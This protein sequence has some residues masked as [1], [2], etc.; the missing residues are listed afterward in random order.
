MISSEKRPFFYVLIA[1]L[2]FGM[3]ALFTREA[4]A[5][6]I[7][8][9]TWRAI[10]VA[11]LFGI[12][13]VWKKD[14]NNI[15]APESLKISVPYGLFLGLAS[16]TFVG[17]YAFTTVANTIFLHNL[18]PLFAIPLALWKFDEKAHP[19]IIAGALLCL[20]GVGLI[21]GVSLFHASHF[22][23]SRFLLGDF[24]A[25]VSAFGYAGVLVWTKLTRKADLPVLGTLFVAW[26]VAAVVLVVLSLFLGSLAISW[27]SFLWILGLAFF[28]TNLPFYFLNL[29]MKHVSA[30]MASLLSMSEILFAT[31]LGVLIYSETLA[32]IGWVGGILVVAGV[33]YPFLPEAEK[34]EEEYEQRPESWYKQRQNRTLFWLLS[35][36]TAVFLGEYEGNYILAMLCFLQ[37]IQIGAPTLQR[38]LDYRYQNAQRFGTGLLALGLLYVLI[39]T[40]FSLPSPIILLE[41]AFLYLGDTYFR[42]QEEALNAQENALRLPEGDIRFILAIL[43]FA[44]VFGLFDHQAQHIL[45]KASLFL[46]GAIGL[47][48]AIS[49]FRNDEQSRLL[50]SIRFPRPKALVVLLSFIFVTGGIYVVPV[51]HSALVER[52]GHFVVAKESG[53]LIRLPPPIERIDIFDAQQIVQLDIWEKEQNLLCGDQSMLSVKASLHVKIQNPQ[54]YRYSASQPA[55]I[56]MHQTRSLLVDQIRQ[57]PHEEL[58]HNRGVLSESWKADLQKRSD[59]QQL[60]LQIISLHFT[61]L[62]VPPAV[63]DSFL[64]V[65]SAIEDQNTEINRAKA[66]ASSSLPKALG[67]AMVTHESALSDVLRIQAQTETWTQHASALHE[68]GR[69]Q[70]SLLLDWVK[71]EI[72]SQKPLQ[73]PIIRGSQCDI[74][75][76]SPTVPILEATP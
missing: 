56:L 49:V 29:G 75:V 5:S 28:C 66:Y 3:M 19:N 26:S 64:D 18:A 53:L 47:G 63:R 35:L 59:Q 27:T 22:T 30:G 72:Y 76:G 57:I 43:A 70:S 16:S 71:Q 55:E 39:N 52:F 1:M 68:G 60:G 40:S 58:L 17:G 44:V 33:L 23:N 32:P 12:A 14:L 2:G 24:L 9:A 13:A 36:N 46:G 41:I 7:T 65:L 8:I 54:T 61:Y 74:F 11:I 4:N 73:N 25:V 10:D 42:Q 21:S 38:L 67:E 6:V 37:L 62:S 34:R 69:D 15:T 50:S 51:G 45:F 20:V 31:L 48:T